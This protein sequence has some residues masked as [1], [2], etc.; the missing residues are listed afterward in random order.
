MIAALDAMEGSLEGYAPAIILLT[1]GHSNE[2]SFDDFEARW[3]EGSP[4]GVPVYSIL[5]GDATEEQLVQVSELTT[6]DTYD[7]RDGLIDAL[8]DSF[9]NV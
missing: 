6:G 1:D 7:G 4:E 9:A 8:R 2:G 3:R 5:F